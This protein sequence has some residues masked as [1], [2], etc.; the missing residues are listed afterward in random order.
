MDIQYIAESSLALAQYVSGYVTKAEK[1]NLQEEWEN[2]SDNKSVRSRLFS[3]GC[4][5]IRSRECG[6]DEGSDLILG[7]SLCKKS[8]VVQWVDVNM[9]DKRRHRLKDHKKLKEIAESDPDSEDVF[10]QNLIESYYPNRPEKLE[11][12]CLY[13]FV[14]NYNYYGF[15][16]KG[17]R[18]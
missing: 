7:D 12:V 8:T 6:L 14:A 9:P 2:I 15:D 13:D 17:K 4:R 18:N 10:E 3:F 1:S 5:M 16:K 11:D